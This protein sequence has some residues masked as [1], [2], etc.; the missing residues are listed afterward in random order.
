M[1]PSFKDEKD[2]ADDVVEHDSDVDFKGCGS[3]SKPQCY[4]QAELNDL[5]RDLGLSKVIRTASFK[6]E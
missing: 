4:N 3:I 6:T 2:I 5:V 1:L